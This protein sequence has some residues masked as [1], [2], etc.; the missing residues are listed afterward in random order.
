V[1]RIR[2]AEREDL[3]ILFTLDRQCFRPG[4]AYSRA[5]L[6]DLLSCPTC[7]PVAAED[8]SSN[9]V[10]FAIAEVYV[11]AGKRIGHI[12]TIDVAPSARR[13]G[14]GRALMR[15]MLDGLRSHQAIL[16]RLEVA[17][18]NPDAQSFYSQ[19]GFVRTRRIPGFYL[20]TVDA[21]AMQKV[22]AQ[23]ECGGK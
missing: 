2:K 3:E 17:V 4:I 1:I 22:L 16:V 20:G 6:R 11:E 10:G 8:T 14:V 5:E 12:V 7:I 21:L 19:Q 13:Q 15:A 9:I 18:D 23:V